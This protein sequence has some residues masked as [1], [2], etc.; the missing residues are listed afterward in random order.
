MQ[1]QNN[2]TNL[3]AHAPVPTQLKLAAAWTSFMFLYA[4]VDILGFYT[5]GVIED[6]LAG[7]VFEF[8]ITQTFLVIGLSLMA[9]PIA[10]IALSTIL[11]PRANRIANLVVASLYVPITVF[12][13]VGE[14]WTYY[15]W[16]AIGLEL[17]VLALI[18]RLA[19]ALPR[20]T[21][22]SREWSRNAAAAN[23]QA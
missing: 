15:Y 23:P 22:P 3:P 4:Y 1:R 20:A 18:V 19:W 6:I 7:V 8:Q 21:N 14:S 11:P 12:N 10:M 16:G 9:L 5:P 2:D 17:A 13:A